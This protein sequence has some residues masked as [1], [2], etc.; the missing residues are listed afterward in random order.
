VVHVIDDVLVPPTQSITE[1]VV[2]AA[3]ADTDAQF[4]LLLAAL[5][6]A[7]DTDGDLVNLLDTEG[8][9]YTVFAPTDQAFTDAGFAEVAD[10]EAADPATLRAILLYHVLPSAVLSTDLTAGSVAT[11]GGGEITINLGDTVTITDVD[12]GGAG[13]SDATVIDTN[14][15]ATNG[16]IHV[17]NQVLLP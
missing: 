15:L 17:I 9:P 6:N 12:S 5:Q 13:S 8:G 4:T 11:V 3:N 16:V 10:I 2:A 1:I 14:I 7:D